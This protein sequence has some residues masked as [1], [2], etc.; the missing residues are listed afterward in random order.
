MEFRQGGEAEFE[1][2]VVG[3]TRRQFPG[4]TIGNGF[5][6]PARIEL[7]PYPAQFLHALLDLTRRR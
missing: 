3:L 5:S 2:R 7:A 1:Y 4:G 6:N